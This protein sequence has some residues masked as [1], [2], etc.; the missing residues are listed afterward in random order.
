MRKLPWM[1]AMVLVRVSGEIDTAVQHG[2]LKFGITKM[3]FEVV[4][5]KK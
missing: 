2:A 1:V 4:K 5:D 3:K